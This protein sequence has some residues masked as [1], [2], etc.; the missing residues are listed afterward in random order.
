MLA[1]LTDAQ[2]DYYLLHMPHVE[3][4]KNHASAQ[5]TADLREFIF[6]RY[7]DPDPDEKKDAKPPRRRQAWTVAETLPPH[8]KYPEAAPMPQ[9]AARA[10][11]GAYDALPAWARQIVPLDEAKAV[12]A[13]Q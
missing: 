10:L 13:A 8:A 5:L 11:L 1:G 2:V 4:R 3:A 9:E 7:L 6:P 12:L